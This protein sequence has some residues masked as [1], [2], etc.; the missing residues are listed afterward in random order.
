MKQPVAHSYGWEEAVSA[1]GLTG[2]VLNTPS[3]WEAT[4]WENNTSLGQGQ[5]AGQIGLPLRTHSKPD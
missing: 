1:V 5:R 3:L 4:D 2:S